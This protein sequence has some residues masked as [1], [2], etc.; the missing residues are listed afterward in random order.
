MNLEVI[1]IKYTTSNYEIVMNVFYQVFLPVSILIAMM[2]K[3]S[4][5]AILLAIHILFFPQGIYQVIKNM[6]FSSGIL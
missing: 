5:F 4:E 1:I 6:K 2:I 3:N